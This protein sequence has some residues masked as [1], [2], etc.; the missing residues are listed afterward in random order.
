MTLNFVNLIT[1]LYFEAKLHKFECFWIFSN[2]ISC[3]SSGL[4]E[5]KIMIFIS[6]CNNDAYYIIIV[7]LA[8]LTLQAAFLRSEL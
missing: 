1:L 2:D 4:F 6:I 3:G 7:F 5:L 8:F